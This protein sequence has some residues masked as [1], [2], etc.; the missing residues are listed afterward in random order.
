[1]KRYFTRFDVLEWQGVLFVSG[2]LSE[3]SQAPASWNEFDGIFILYCISNVWLFKINAKRLEEI[4]VMLH[5][6]TL[7]KSNSYSDI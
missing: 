3:I 7:P 5:G 2:K 4:F 6:Q 1:M